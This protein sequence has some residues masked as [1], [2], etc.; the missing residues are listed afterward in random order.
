MKTRKEREKIPR[1]NTKTLIMKQ[2]VRKKIY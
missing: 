1:K 2:L